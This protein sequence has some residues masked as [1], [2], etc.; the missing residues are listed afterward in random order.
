M[1]SRSAVAWVPV[2]S[3]GSP[4]PAATRP[5]IVAVATSASLA[6]VTALAAMVVAPS[7]AEVTSPEWFGCA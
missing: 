7:P 4:A 2:R 6:F 5:L 1:T 3:S